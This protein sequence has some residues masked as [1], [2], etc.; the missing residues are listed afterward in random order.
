M[1]IYSGC[2]VLMLWSRLIP[3]LLAASVIK[4]AAVGAPDISQF[5][6]VLE[7]TKAGTQ[8]GELR[9]YAEM[10][11]SDAIVGSGLPPIGDAD[12]L[13]EWLRA[14]SQAKGRDVAVDAWGRPFLLEK[15]SN[16]V[17]LILSLGPN[18]NRDKCIE[19]VTLTAD[20]DDICE[21]VEVPPEAMRKAQ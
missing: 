16:S 3:L 5:S 13:A 8:R 14:N 7:R 11:E 4:T 9:S 17:A 10:L 2:E 12:K 19:G 6:D 1:Y 21:K 15:Q 18:G 20:E